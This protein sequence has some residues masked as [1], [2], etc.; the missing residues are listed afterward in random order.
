MWRILG[1]VIYLLGQRVFP[2]SFLALYSRNL[3]HLIWIS[4]SGELSVDLPTPEMKKFIQFPA[5]VRF[6][7]EAIVI[8]TTDSKPADVYVYHLKN[9]ICYLTTAWI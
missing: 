5:L 9:N 6:I 4:D 3:S 1:T 7:F 2:S 8:T